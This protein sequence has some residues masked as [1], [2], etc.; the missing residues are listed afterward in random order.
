MKRRSKAGEKVTAARR[1]TTPGQQR[2]NGP[3]ALRRGAASVA[4]RRKDVA[5]RLKREL[6]EVAERQVATSEMLR[7]ISSSSGDLEPVFASILA[8]AVRLCGADSGVI[9]RWDGGALHLIATHNMPQAFVNLRSRSPYRPNQHSASGR[10]LTSKAP[11]HIADLAKDRSYLEGNPP[12]VAAV[13]VVGIRT[14][15]AVPMWKGDELVGSFSLGRNKVRPFTGKQIEVVQ[16][17][18]AQ[19]VVA[20]ENARLLHELRE[21][22]EQQIAAAD[23]LKIISRSTFDLQTVLDTLLELVVRLCGAELG[24]LHPKRAN[25]RAYATYGGP[26]SHAEVASTVLFEPDRG[27]V[28][29]RTALEGRP[30]QVADV[31]ADPEYRL[32]GAQQKLGYRTCLGVPLLRDGEP[33]G[34]IVLMRFA[35]HPFTDKQIELAQNFAAQAVVAIENAR[36]LTELR[37]RTDALGRTVAELQR[38]RKNKLMNLE[39]MLASVSHEVRQ[40]L[41]SIVS[42]GGAAIRFLGH[43]P[44]NLDEVRAALNRMVGESHRASQIFDNIRALFGKADQGH[45]TIDANELVRGVLSSLQGELDDHG[46]TTELDLPTDVP[47]I[48]G[49]KGQL[50]EV[51]VNLIRN[52]IEAMQGD[53]GNRRVLQMSALSQGANKTMIA[54]ADSGPGIDPKHSARIFDAFI[55]TKAHGTG[56]GLALARMIVERHGGQLAVT[57]AQPRGSIFR[58]V[59]PAARDRPKAGP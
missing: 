1:R 33:I 29:G 11:V 59:L 17:F 53:D 51:L 20:I 8:S 49:H 4:Q 30:V 56:L 25:F 10:M 45:E 40:P 28:M 22:L 54:V 31:L 14:V 47:T 2:R 27:S 18:G 43:A 48:M 32:Q 36:L 52:A 26:A 5:W 9:N 16:N 39:A 12:T 57:P 15:L 7:L 55:T 34:V 44:P 3:K 13:D 37:Q 42:N 38:E 23:I 24:A 58:I 6:Q 19:A 21:T 35:V 50:Q 46:I 41:A